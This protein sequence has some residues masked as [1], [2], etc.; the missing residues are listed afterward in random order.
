MRPLQWK[1]LVAA[2]AIA[3]A[4]TGLL[5]AMAIDRGAAPA[6]VPLTTVPVAVGLGLLVLWAAWVVRQFKLGKRKRLDPV[7]AV[8]TAILAQACAYAGGLLAGTYGGYALVL[9]RDWGHEPRRE[10]A[11][12]AGLA[13][14]SGLFMLAAGVIA[15]WWC[16]IT[17][18]G[19]DEPSPQEPEP[20]MAH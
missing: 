9:A 7:R 14:L 19:D 3:A 5:S 15:E 10:L 1:Y 16:R 20:G 13:A 8:R 11:I 2:V 4:G 6:R 12:A 18:D 17:Q